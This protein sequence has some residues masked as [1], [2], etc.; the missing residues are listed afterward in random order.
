MYQQRNNK[1]TSSSHQPTNIFFNGLLFLLLVYAA[2]R[3]D[4]VLKF[5][6]Y[7]GVG[8]RTMAKLQTQWQRNRFM[9]HSWGCVTPSSGVMNVPNPMTSAMSSVFVGSSISG[10][11]LLCNSILW[12]VECQKKEGFPNSQILKHQT[13]GFAVGDPVAILQ[14]S[15]PVQIHR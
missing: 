14:A 11:F 3:Q 10:H 8:N 12:I 5:W 4:G 13:A 2:C 1:H 7:N 6:R 15:C 9:V